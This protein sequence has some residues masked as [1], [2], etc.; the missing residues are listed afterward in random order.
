MAILGAP[1]NLAG[2]IGQGVIPNPNSP[3]VNI[4]FQDL[5]GRGNLIAH[6]RPDGRPHNWQD[7]GHGGI[8]VPGGEVNPHGQ[9][10]SNTWGDGT[11]K[12]HP[13]YR[14]GGKR[15]FADGTPVTSK[16]YGAFKIN[17]DVAPGVQ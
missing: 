8:R 11:V 7:P 12:N 2:M 14:Q 6:A 4:G 15:T 17:P 10:G 13:L 9:R 1:G 5:L 16:N 3:A